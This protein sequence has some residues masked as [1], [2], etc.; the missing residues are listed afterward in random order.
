VRLSKKIVGLD[1]V[2]FSEM[3]ENHGCKSKKNV[4]YHNILLSSQN[5]Q[6]GSVVVWRSKKNWTIT[7]TYIIKYPKLL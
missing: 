4:N 5:D 2:P 7:N 1:L 3:V 6:T